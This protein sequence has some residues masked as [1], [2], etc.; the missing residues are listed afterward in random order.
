M[1]F[2]FL[3]NPRIG[4]DKW[5]GCCDYSTGM[6]SILDADHAHDTIGREKRGKK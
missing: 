5:K 3:T 2:D 4:S 6:N 1:A